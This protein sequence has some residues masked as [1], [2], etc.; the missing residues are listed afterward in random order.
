MDRGV[1]LWAGL[2]GGH[3]VRLWLSTSQGVGGV[4]WAGVGDSRIILIQFGGR[5]PEAHVAGKH[6][7]PAGFRS[8]SSIR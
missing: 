7:L 3:K 1:A 8:L 2:V 5:R 4:G 6:N